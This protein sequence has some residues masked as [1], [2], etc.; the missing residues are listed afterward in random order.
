LGKTPEKDD[1]ADVSSNIPGTETIYIRT[2]G[3]SHN[4]SDGEYM[5]GMLAEAGYNVTTCLILIHVVAETST[6]DADIADLWIL[7]SCTVKTPS[8]SLHV[9]A[10]VLPLRGQLQQHNQAGERTRQVC[11]S[12]RVRAS[13]TT[14][15]QDD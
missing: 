7:N 13:G 14:E 1:A 3:C 15:R 10:H 2:W 8:G 4:N 9:S 11:G 12:C 6:A 5:A